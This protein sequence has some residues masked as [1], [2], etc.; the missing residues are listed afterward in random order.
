MKVSKALYDLFFNV[1]VSAILSAILS[2]AMLIVNV[3]FV[4]G[5]TVMWLKSFAT[6]IIFAVPSTYLAIPLVGRILG[7]ILIV[8]KI[9]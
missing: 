1:L 5:F 6:S 9:S 3:G 8:K 2:F 7:G 4:N